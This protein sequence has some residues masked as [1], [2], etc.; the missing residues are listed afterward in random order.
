M[1][2]PEWSLFGANRWVKLSSLW[3]FPALLKSRLLTRAAQ[4]G[5]YVLVGC[6]SS[7]TRHFIRRN[8][9]K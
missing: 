4:F 2:H 1:P 9:L 3:K 6:D 5:V 8:S 7:V